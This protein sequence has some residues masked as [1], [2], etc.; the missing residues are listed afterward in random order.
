MGV[1]AR[2]VVPSRLR[3]AR[4]HAKLSQS[5]LAGQISAHFTSI[6]DWER[7]KNQP[8]A[9]HLASIARETGKPLEFFFGD[10]DDEEDASDMVADLVHAL[11]R[12]V[13]AKLV[14]RGA[15]A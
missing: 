4:T 14:R 9:R 1:R 8:S 6:S 3:E 13:E 10:A 2:G 11:D 7:G 15:A 5:Q 12:Y